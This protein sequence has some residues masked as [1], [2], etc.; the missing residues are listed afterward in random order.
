MLIQDIIAKKRDG[1]RLSR[2]EIEFFITSYTGGA[3]PDY[4]A[5]ALIMAIFIRGFNGEELSYFANA[6]LHSGTVVDLSHIP[7]IKVDK[8]S[9]GGVGDK[10]SIPLAPLVASCG[11]RVPMVSGRGLGH[12]GGTLDKLEAIPGFSVRLSLD[13][14]A[15]IVEEVGVCMIGQTEELA[16]ADRKI[17]SLRDATG[18]VPSIPLI[19]SS[20]MSKKLAEGI[21]ALV[22][23][24]KVGTG[25]F[26]PT[27]E[28][29]EELA[30]TLVDIGVRAGKRV[31]AFLTRMDDPLGVAVGNACEVIESIDVLRGGGPEDIR[32]LTLLMASHMLVMGGVAPDPA[33]ARLRCQAALADGSAIR[34]F[35]ELISAQGGNP[36]A[37]ERTDLFAK[38]AHAT[39][40]RADRSG[41]VRAVNS[42]AIG[43]AGVVLGA[44]R[45]Q[46]T[47]LVDPGVSLYVRKKIGDPVSA[48]DVLVDVHYNDDRGLADALGRIAGA[49]DIGDGPVAPGPL[50]LKTI[51]G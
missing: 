28:K 42:T 51:E 7:G 12:T 9:T 39:S 6:M 44:G 38:A 5:A 35:Q 1:L 24:V 29:A 4:Q 13:T 21:D 43:M 40:V 22:L 45:R 50:V 31:T 47:D 17:Y 36:E 2:E 46:V 49:Y 26:M 48:G 32:E 30:R 16:P 34:K 3:L 14:Y 10:I 19:A 11:V 25:A 18:C 15:R 41:V 20:I 8:H 27:E 37:V 33:A 23:D